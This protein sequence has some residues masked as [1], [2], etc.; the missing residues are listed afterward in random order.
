[1]ECCESGNLGKNLY[2]AGIDYNGIHYLNNEAAFQ[3]QKCL[4]DEEKWEFA[5][6]SAAKA[7]RKG[8]QVSLRADWG[9]VKIGIMEEI[10]RCKFTQNP[11]LAD[12][13]LKTGSRKLVEGN[14]WHDNFWGN[15]S[16]PK[17]AG[18]E[19]KNMLGKILM[20]E[21]KSLKEG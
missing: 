3:A 4:T 18:K 13:L 17:C 9:Q 7:K 6:L 8:R 11:H 16:C 14:T 10:V 19:K 2:E 1:M 5:Y 15:C 20:E 12:R 21:R